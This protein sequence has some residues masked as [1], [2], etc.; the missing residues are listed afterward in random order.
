MDTLER[1]TQPRDLSNYRVK[2][3][4]PVM[5]PA[6][7]QPP[8]NNAMRSP[9]PQTITTSGEALRQFSIPPARQ[10]RIFLPNVQ[11]ANN[12]IAPSHNQA[13]SALRSMLISL[14][15]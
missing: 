15:K 3:Q 10:Q 13:Q 7:Y 14:G 6:A 9:V 1:A 8:Q 5:P 4:A 2:T 11:V 12:S